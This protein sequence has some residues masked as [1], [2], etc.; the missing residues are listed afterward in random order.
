MSFIIPPSLEKSDL[1]DEY[2]S[3]F[4]KTAE[5][6]N[7]LKSKGIDEETLTYVLL[8]GNTLDFTITMNARELLLFLSLRTCTRAQWEIQN[9]A[10]DMLSILRQCSPSVFKHFGPSCFV[11]GVCPEGRLS[12]GQIREVKEK[13]SK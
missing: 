12:C 9:Y 1:L 6:Y 10:N 7:K 4:M 5:L 11:K 3:C 13:Y 2:K 8:A